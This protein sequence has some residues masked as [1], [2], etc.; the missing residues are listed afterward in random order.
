MHTIGNTIRCIYYIGNT[1]RCIYY[2]GNTIRCIYYI[3]NTIRC[4]YYIGN[5][6]S[7][8]RKVIAMLGDDYSYFIVLKFSILSGNSFFFT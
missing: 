2:I 6:I 3:G 8:F 5:T 1:I 7:R 4:I